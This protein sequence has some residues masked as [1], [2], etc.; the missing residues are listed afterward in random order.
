ML[1][2]DKVYKHPFNEIWD[3]SPRQLEGR[4]NDTEL[5]LGYSGHC[6]VS[7]FE[8]G[9][10]RYQIGVQHL[11]IYGTIV[12]NLLEKVCLLGRRFCKI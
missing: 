5:Y 10:M 7:S 11:P 8:I 1:L 9:D 12:F 3:L 2:N 6:I 4:V